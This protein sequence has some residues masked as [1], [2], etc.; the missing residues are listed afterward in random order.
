MMNAKDIEQLLN[1]Y[2]QCE[3]SVEEEAQLR[4][5][6]VAGEVPEHLLRYRELFVCQRIQQEDGLDDAFDARMLELIEPRS[7]KQRRSVLLVRLAPF[8]KAAAAVALMVVLSN[9][10]QRSFVPET[11]ETALAA[12]T[13]GQQ[14]SAPSIALSGESTSAE[15]SFKESAG[16]EATSAPRSSDTLTVVK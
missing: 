6:F 15:V 9:V 14:V 3:T 5:L 16:K 11:S 1:R 2:W 12:D 7:S 13:V 4:E 10:M 8:F